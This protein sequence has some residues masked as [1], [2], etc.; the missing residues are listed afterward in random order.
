MEVALHVAFKT[1]SNVQLLL[2]QHVQPVTLAFLSL[3]ITNVKEFVEESSVINVQVQ[4]TVQHVLQDILLSKVDAKFVLLQIVYLVFKQVLRSVLNVGRD[5]ILKME[6]AMLVHLPTV[7][8]AIP[9]HASLL[10]PQQIKSHLLTIKAKLLQ[11]YV[12]LNVYHA[13]I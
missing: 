4:P 1:V 11:S 10:K 13:L 7:K 12:I 6:L 8:H 5:I 2:L 9:L 3:L